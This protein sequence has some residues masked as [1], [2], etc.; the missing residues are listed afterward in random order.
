MSIIDNYV[1]VPTEDGDFILTKD[2]C[3]DYEL[4]YNVLIKKIVN[5][6][7]SASHFCMSIH[8]YVK[9]YPE[10]HS[11]TNALHKEFPLFRR[12]TSS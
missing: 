12:V 2:E 8:D 1:M 7:K 4:D 11:F 10:R 5:T 6:D 3:S 9:I